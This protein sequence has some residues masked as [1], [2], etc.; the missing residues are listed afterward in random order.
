MN[1]A[2]WTLTLMVGCAAPPP[3]ASNRFAPVLSIHTDDGAF[4]EF[5]AVAGTLTADGAVDFSGSALAVAGLWAPKE[6]SDF[7]IEVSGSIGDGQNT[8]RLT[9]RNPNLPMLDQ[10]VW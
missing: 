10:G 2:F 5:W 7:A 4:A 1:R 3:E 8:G 6:P 9:A